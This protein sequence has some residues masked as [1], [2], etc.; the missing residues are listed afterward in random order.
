[1]LG[2]DDVNSSNTSRQVTSLVLFWRGARQSLM[3]QCNKLEPAAVGTKFQHAA[4][5]WTIRHPVCRKSQQMRR[6]R[7]GW[8]VP[9]MGDVAEVPA[10]GRPNLVLSVVQVSPS[11]L[12]ELCCHSF[13]W[14][15]RS[16]YDTSILPILLDVWVL[17]Q[18]CCISPLTYENA[19]VCTFGGGK[20]LRQLYFKHAPQVIS[21]FLRL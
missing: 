10:V 13:S 12:H 20:D 14:N 4:V 9:A 17:S 7:K 21:A 3:M 15:F 1:M 16:S 11:T 5:R 6:T 18:A 8:D 2:W 19:P